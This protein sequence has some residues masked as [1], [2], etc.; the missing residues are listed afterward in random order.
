M[1]CKTSGGNAFDSRRSW[2]DTGGHL[3]PSP[4]TMNGAHCR[5]NFDLITHSVH[6]IASEVMMR[7]IILLSLLLAGCATG[8]QY[9]DIQANIHP[10]APDKGR[11][12]F[13]RTAWPPAVG[14]QPVI[15][16]NGKAVGK[17]QPDGFFFIDVE[18][19]NVRVEIEKSVWEEDI[20]TLAREAST[21]I[22]PKRR[23]WDKSLSFVIKPRQTLYIET[24]ANLRD[25]N[26]DVEL[27]KD[28]RAR[29]RL[30][31]RK[32]TNPITTQR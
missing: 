32:F 3:S 18:P 29:K 2:L 4:T 30:G 12:Y 24:S 11:I 20:T 15:Y 28:E 10:V 27:V 9:A 23:V 22:S 19:G 17:S 13:Y 16:V 1:T 5:H 25:K 8:P 7:F 31:A 14:M 26:I 21:G 6:N